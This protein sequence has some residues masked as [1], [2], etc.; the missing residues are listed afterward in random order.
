MTAEPAAPSAYHL[1]WKTVEVQGRRARY[2][3]AGDGA[4]FVF[5]HGWGLTERTYKRALRRLVELGV[6]VIAPSLPGFGG[7]AE[8]SE[9]KISLDSYA[10][11]VRD[12]L[13]TIGVAGA[14]Y[15]AGHS[16]G[17]GVAIKV[18]H[19]YPDRVRLLVL[20]NSIGGAV[21]K[22]DGEEDR[23]HLYERPL[24][25]WGLHLPW[26][27]MRSRALNRVVPVVVTDIV[28]NAMRNPVAFWR[29]AH[30]ARRA[31]LRS[32]LEDLKRR[33]L[34][35]VV[36]WGSGDSIIPSVSGEA[37][38][39]AL[40]EE[41]ETIEGSHGWMLADPDAFGEVMTNVVAFAE[42][43]RHQ[44]EREHKPAKSDLGSLFEEG[45]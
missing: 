27:T 20:L 44:E 33:E 3:E 7:T 39:R 45:V 2:A 10:A 22:G 25:D 28:Q 38:G 4:P 37:L 17:G 26:D 14:V 15:L 6:R 12:F 5:L 16:F 24:W 43:A 11:W 31:D 19:T 9:E 8:L 40:G 1:E 35:V 36:L 23:K 30:I 41:V 13:D 32:E 18:A 21:W 42:Y 29:V 34:P